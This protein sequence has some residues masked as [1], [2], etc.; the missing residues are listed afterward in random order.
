[1]IV[2]EYEIIILIITMKSQNYQRSQ[3]S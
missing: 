2:N 1:M 3:K